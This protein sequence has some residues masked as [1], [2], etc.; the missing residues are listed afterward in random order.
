MS[1]ADSVERVCAIVQAALESDEFVLTSPFAERHGAYEAR[2]CRCKDPVASVCLCLA[3]PQNDAAIRV[4]AEIWLVV[5]FA[6]KAERHLARS[7]SIPIPFRA[8]HQ[9]VLKLELSRSLATAVVGGRRA[10]TCAAG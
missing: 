6:G 1:F 8:E 10:S 2:F 4:E 7:F 9:E 5:G 3:P